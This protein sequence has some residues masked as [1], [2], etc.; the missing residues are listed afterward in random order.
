MRWNQ[1]ILNRTVYEIQRCEGRMKV[2]EYEH[3]RTCSV[4]DNL[5]DETKM[6]QA[7]F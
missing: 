1:K 3:S 2:Q 4:S 7:S 6:N 5:A